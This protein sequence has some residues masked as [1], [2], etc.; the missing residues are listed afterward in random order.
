MA[1]VGAS[2]AC[3]SA[4]SSVANEPGA[5]G[6]AQSP[7]LV[8]HLLLLA[9]VSPRTHDVLIVAPIAGIAPETLLCKSGLVEKAS[10]AMS[11]LFAGHSR[12]PESSSAG[13]R[14][15][16]LRYIPHTG[17]T[18]PKIWGSP[19]ANSDRKRAGWG[20]AV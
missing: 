17:E 15:T 7:A 14:L 1:V 5:Q 10:I 18:N 19:T 6:K 3:Q 13:C 16:F 11:C 2:D 8:H 12:S 9:G 4:G 20:R